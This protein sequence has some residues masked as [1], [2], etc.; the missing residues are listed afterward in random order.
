L[1][2]NPAST[3][4]FQSVRDVT[5]V[6]LDG[7]PNWRLAEERL[8]AALRAAGETDT[9]VARLA[10]RSPEEASRIGFRGSPTVIVDGRDLFAEG[11]PLVGLACRVY[12]TPE[13]PQGSPTV[14]QLLEAIRR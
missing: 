6:Y 8:R 4:T 3:F 13:G 12:E 14:A 1:T 11:G 2:F 10:V 9:P 5:L 7:C